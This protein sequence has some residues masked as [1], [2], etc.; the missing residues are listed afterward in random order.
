MGKQPFV[1]GTGGHAR[2]VAEILRAAGTEPAGFVIPRG[3]SAPE[4]PPALPLR[5]WEEAVAEKD[6]FSVIV[7]IGDNMLRQ[8]VSEAAEA[9]GFAF[10]TAVHPAAVVG[11]GVVLEPGSVVCAGAV[12]VLDVTIGRGTI[13]NT[14]ASVDHDCV[15]GRW[16]HL[17]PGS[18]L[19]GAVRLG[20]G[21]FV[22]AGAVIINGI[23]VGS[24]SVVGAGAVVVRDLSETVVAVGVPAVVLRDGEN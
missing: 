21:A 20:D 18:V 15:V 17:G 4:P 7:G 1:I 5:T 24:H 6:R 11:P 14:R 23:S 13:V 12:L 10:T 19:A 9:E 8:E 22:G 3:Q 2:V 16:C